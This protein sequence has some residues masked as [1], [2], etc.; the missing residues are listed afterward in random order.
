MYYQERLIFS[1]I[2]VSRLKSETGRLFIQTHNFPDPDA[3]AAAFGLKELLE[4]QG[5]HSEIIYDGELQRDALIRMIAQL[6]IPIY[7]WKQYE[8]TD[9]DGIVIVDGCK[10]NSNVEDLVG[11]E[12]AVIDHHKSLTTEDVELTD[13]RP[14]YGSSSTMICEY[15]QELGV[16][17]SRAAASALQ[18]GLARDTDLYTRGMTEKDLRALSFLYPFSDT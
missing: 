5:I 18:I 14:D 1:E 16:M 7:H 12:I 17:P 3:V 13:I 8:L 15:Y 4:T 11:R 6:N 9:N 2:L 10:G